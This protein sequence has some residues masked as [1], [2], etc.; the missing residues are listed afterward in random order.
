MLG[1]ISQRPD[2]EI[3]KGPDNL[4]CASNKKYAIFECK[5]EVDE[6]RGAIK[7][8]EAGSTSIN[9]TIAELQLANF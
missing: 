4:W 2:Q 7:K 8:S 1:Y 5:S 6:N 9:K 3:R